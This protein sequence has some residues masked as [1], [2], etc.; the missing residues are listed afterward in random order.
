MPDMKMRQPI[1]RPDQEICYY[2]GRRKDWGAFQKGLTLWAHTPQEPHANPAIIELDPVLL[3]N[4][5]GTGYCGIQSGLLEGIYQSRPGGTP[6]KPA[7][8]A[9]RWFLAGIVHS[10]CDAFYDGKWHYYDIDLGGGSATRG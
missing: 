9:R 5:H 4:V 10:V 7:I 6:G 3:L 1:F 8:E 2:D